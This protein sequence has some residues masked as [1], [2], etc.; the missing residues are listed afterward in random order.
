MVQNTQENLVPQVYPMRLIFPKRLKI[1]VLSTSPLLPEQ[2]PSTPVCGVGETGESITP[3]TEV[4]VSPTLPTGEILPYSC[5][6]VLSCDKS[7]NSEAQSVIKP[8]VDPLTEEVEV[9]SRL[10]DGDLA[11][12]KGPES[13]ILAAGAELVDLRSPEQVPHGVQP[14]FDQTPMSINVESDKEEEEE[15][16]SEAVLTHEPTEYAKQRKRKSKGKTIESHSKGDKKSAIAANVIQ[17]ERA[18][19]RRRE[20][21]LPEK[22]TSTPFPVRSSDTEYDD[23]ATY[24]A[25]KRK[26]GE[27]K[28]VKSKGIQK[29]AKKSPV[30][31]ERVR[32]KVTAK[33]SSFKGPCPSVQNPVADKEMTREES[34]VEIENQKVLNRRVFDPDILIA[35]GMSNLFDVVFYKPEVREFYYNI[36]LLENVGIRTTVNNI[37]IFLDEESLGII[38]G[39]LDCKLSNEFPKQATKRRDIKRAGLSNKF[40]KGEYQLLFVFINK[41]LVP[42]TEKR[43]VASATD[44]FLME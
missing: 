28:R 12:G 3:L 40:L 1:P 36:E 16:A 39:V 44:L 18:M 35:F 38:L 37:K 24:V 23:V 42:R 30:K 6:L 29:A 32:K 26:E 27:D 25:K 33:S 15:S 34:I 43:T 22:P 41:V 5:T 31:K 14:M 21:H 4:V 8:S 9:L 17:T 10:F 19:K 2:S 11:E 7:Q 13:N 20:G